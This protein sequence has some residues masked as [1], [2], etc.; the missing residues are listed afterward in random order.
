MSWSSIYKKM[1]I[2]YL[3]VNVYQ[4]YVLYTNKVFLTQLKPILFIPR[5]DLVQFLFLNPTFCHTLTESYLLR[6]IIDCLVVLLPIL[7]FIFITF[8][9]NH[10]WIKIISIVTS[11]VLFSYGLLIDSTT[12]IHFEGYIMLGLYSLVFCFKSHAGFYY[13]FSCYRYFFVYVF[14]SAGLWKL[15]TGA[16]FNND[17]MS[18]ILLEQH[19]RYLAYNLND[20]Y[21]RT[22]YFLINSPKLSYS[23]YCLAIIIQLSFIFGFFTKKFDRIFLGLFVL[24]IV[25]D[26]F[27]MSINYFVW[28]GYGVVL[29]YSKFLN[30][31]VR[32]V[33]NELHGAL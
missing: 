3:M 18:S 15:R 32:N 7:L 19:L 17:Q 10:F 26:Y 20:Y 16:I 30:P 24:F 31:P 28:L 2:V 9:E 21:S 33:Y 29:Y 23:I 12:L 1:G 4:Y 6:L 25:S 13:A 5:L 14:S 11:F 27:L 8:C 22:I